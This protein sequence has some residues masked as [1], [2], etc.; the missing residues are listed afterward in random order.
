VK[1]PL[2]LTRADWVLDLSFSPDGRFLAAGGQ[3]FLYVFDTTTWELEWAP[4]HVNDGWTLQTE[5]LDDGRTIATS[6][7]DGTV[8]LFDA[9]RGLVRARALPASGEAGAGYAYL[10]P[11]AEDELVVL[12][13][14]RSGRRYPLDPSV[15][16]DE[17]CAIVGG[18]DLT[19]AEQER[20]L[21]GRDDRPT[22]SDL[23]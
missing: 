15:W 11:G 13:G 23:P 21:P 4:A 1:R 7:S 14:D 8:A 17:A 20:Y 5:W 9:D 2:P 22:C 19:P 16:L 6:G 3:N 10:V 18:R 12:S